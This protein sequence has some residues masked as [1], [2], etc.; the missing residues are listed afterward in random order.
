MTAS[1]HTQHIPVQ[2]QT[3]SVDAILASVSLVGAPDG[4]TGATP[5]LPPHHPANTAADS[6]VVRWTLRME[7]ARPVEDP[8]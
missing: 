4:E 5:L 2:G 6:P 8:L 3:S 7:L 1:P